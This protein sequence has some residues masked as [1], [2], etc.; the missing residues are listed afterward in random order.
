ML[1]FSYDNA[2]D[3]LSCHNKAGLVRKWMNLTLTML[4]NDEDRP[5]ERY[6]FDIIGDTI[7]GTAGD[8]ISLEIVS[9][10][11]GTAGNTISLRA[12]SLQAK[13]AWLARTLN[14]APEIVQELSCCVLVYSR[15]AWRRRR[16][17]FRYRRKKVSMLGIEKF[18]N[19]FLW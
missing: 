10:I 16:S 7:S 11:S 18:R 14:A 3:T 4:S 8:M 12:A 1:E 9:P 5:D 2:S 17:G 19:V 6:Q 13:E 15:F